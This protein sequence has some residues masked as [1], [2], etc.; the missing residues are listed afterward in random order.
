[1][2]E[3][4]GPLMKGLSLSDLQRLP[5]AA[6]KSTLKSLKSDRTIAP[7]KRRAVLKKVSAPT[8]ALINTGQVRTEGDLVRTLTPNAT[9]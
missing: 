4:L 5:A 2:V 6:L 1:M 8:T 7:A 9:P 3:D